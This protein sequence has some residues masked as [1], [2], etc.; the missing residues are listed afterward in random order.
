MHRNENGGGTGGLSCSPDGFIKHALEIALGQ[1]R[2]LEILLCLDFPA[3]CQRFLI[4]YGLGP[5]LPHALLGCLII[6][7]IQLCTD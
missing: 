1:G 2:A 5:H 6:S 7:Q 3:D 4:L